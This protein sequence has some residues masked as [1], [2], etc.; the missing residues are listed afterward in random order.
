MFR[1]FLILKF[2]KMEL[3]F[4]YKRTQ[5][6]QYVHIISYTLWRWKSCRIRSF[7]FRA[8]KICS[9]NFLTA[10]FNGLK[11]TLFG[12]VTNKM[13]K[14]LKMLKIIN[15]ALRN[16]CNSN[17]TFNHNDIHAVRI[18]IKIK[19]SG[20]TAESLIKQC[21]K[22]L[23]KNFKNENRIK[24][25]LQYQT[26]KLPY[27]T[28]TNDK[29]SLLNQSSVVLFSL[30]IVLFILEKQ[31]ALYWK[32]QKNMPTKIIIRKNKAPSMNTCRV[33]DITTITLIYLMLIMIP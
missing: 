28:N 26:T 15:H 33:L 27:F 12:M 18:Y 21:T 29:I 7:V 10:K 16:K 31:S 22:K 19:H 8:N 14:M 3:E 23:Y 20:E 11:D 25:V 17:N 1:N 24:F 30:V 9:A 5:T 6:G 2:V 32:G 4:Y 13:L